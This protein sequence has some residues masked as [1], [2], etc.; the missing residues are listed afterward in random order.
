[1]ET[2]INMA[3]HVETLTI[4]AQGMTTKVDR[5]ESVSTIGGLDIS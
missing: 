5:I 4:T 3:G 1:M 2:V